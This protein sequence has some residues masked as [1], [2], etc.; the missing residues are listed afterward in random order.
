M[1]WH[2]ESGT[3]GLVDQ[4]AANVRRGVLDGSLADGER[5]P[6]ASDLARTLGV[7]ANTVLAAYRVLRD[8]GLLEF[9]RG[10]GVTVRTSDIDRHA[11]LDAVR[12]LIEVGQRHGYTR[13]E[14]ARLVRTEANS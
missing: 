13:A 6:T 3:G 2:I 11:V 1:L 8:E 10:R 14:L 4:I 9:R 7:N 5:L 12:R